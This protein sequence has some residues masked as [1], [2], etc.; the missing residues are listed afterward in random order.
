MDKNLA[1]RIGSAG[2][3]IAAGKA[4]SQA[5]AKSTPKLNVTAPKPSS[6]SSK[7]Q[8][9][10][11]E[12]AF[13]RQQN[14][15]IN[16][17]FAEAQSLYDTQA[18]QLIQL[19][20]FY[21]QSVIR[22]Y[23]SQR[24]ILQQ[25]FQAGMENIGLQKEQT[26]G[27]R[28]SALAQARRQYEEGLQKSQTLFGG[29]GGSSAGQASAEILGAEQLRQMGS[30]QTQSAQNLMALG[31]AE[32]DLQGQLTTQLQQLEVKKQ[33]D[34]MKLR[35]SFRQELNQI[36]Q[37]KGTLSMNKANAQ[38]A[39]LQDY[40][41]RRRALDDM[42]TEQRMNL[43]TY[44]QQLRLQAQYTPATAKVPDLTNLSTVPLP[45]NVIASNI[46]LYSQTDEGLK[47]LTNAGWRQ[48]DVGNLELWGN[49]RT[50]RTVDLAG[51]EY[52][53]F[54]FAQKITEENPLSGFIK[55]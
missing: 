33:Q 51:N 52:Q 27:Q 14:D 44:A 41:N 21:E 10:N 50:G 39:A 32:R 48:Y 36:N 19:Q 4:A 12:S 22:G 40:N 11:P 35:D 47:G 31:T 6:S 46:D 54:T 2:A 8:G 49:Q 53:P 43:E 5:V 18:Q 15:L 24:P 25:Q 28:E 45:S 3:G 30:A 23:E 20:P 1:K 42:V 9:I 13:L 37:A 26:R 55:K 16:R 7:K 34:L 29:V 17:Q 38:L